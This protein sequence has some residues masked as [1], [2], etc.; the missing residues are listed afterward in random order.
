MKEPL[1]WIIEDIEG[2]VI[3]FYCERDKILLLNFWATWCPPCIQELESLS[4][5]AHSYPKEILV[6]AISYEEKDKIK[7]FLSR[8]FGG[9]LSPEIKFASV[10][11]SEQL[12]YFP[13]DKLPVSYIFNKKGHLKMKESG[14]R[15]WSD[16]KLIKALRN[17]K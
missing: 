4:Q 11:E 16:P 8:S 2:Q 13:K 9:R 14:Y 10:K 3:D 17:L 1:D 7:N 6:V 15:D 12:K 5:L